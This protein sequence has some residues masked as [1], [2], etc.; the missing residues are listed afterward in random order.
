MA[1]TNPH[2]GLPGAWPH[3]EVFLLP[4]SPPLQAVALI[5]QLCT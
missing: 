4:L 2:P 3:A 5:T 1:T